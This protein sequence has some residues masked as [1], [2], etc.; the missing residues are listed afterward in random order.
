MANTIV[1]SDLYLEEVFQ[2]LGVPASALA[3]T[4]LQD[5]VA[6]MTGQKGDTLNIPITPIVDAVA[7]N[8]VGDV[9]YSN[10][11]N[12]TV[13]LTLS[14]RQSNY[15]L[16]PQEKMDTVFDIQQSSK[17]KSGQSIFRWV[18]SQISDFLNLNVRLAT[19]LSSETI[20]TP[21]DMADAEALLTNNEVPL[22][23]RVAAI[24]PDAYHALMNASTVYGAN[25]QGNR[26]IL[27]G[28]GLGKMIGLSYIPAQYATRTLT[29]PAFGAGPLTVKTTAA[30]GLSTFVATGVAV[31]LTPAFVAGTIIQITHA[32]TGEAVNYVIQAD[33]NSD[34]SGDSTLVISPALEAQATATDVFTVKT[35]GSAASYVKN[36]VYNM[37]FAMAASRIVVPDADDLEDYYASDIVP[38][39]GWVMTSRFAPISDTWGRRGVGSS[40]LYGISRVLT[41]FAVCKVSKV[42]N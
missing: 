20:L 40:T 35:G 13:S 28:G 16:S 41:D 5:G 17:T 23:G 9:T 6:L 18:E 25:Y 21:A 14:G 19:G 30:A 36:Y 8:T 7:L 24:N 32:S 2:V 33:A 26:D 37:N 38:G 42:G 27:Q 34:G 29:N 1:N 22:E 11:V 3:P 10:Y 15:A 31:S 12:T 4:F 39:L